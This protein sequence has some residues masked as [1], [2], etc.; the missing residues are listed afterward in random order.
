[1]GLYEIV[2]SGIDPS[3]L[4]S[5]EELIT[6][7]CPQRQGLLVIIQVVSNEIFG[8]IAKLKTPHHKWICWILEDIFLRCYSLQI[9]ILPLRITSSCTQCT[10][11]IQGEYWVSVYVFRL[12]YL[13]RFSYD[14]YNCPYVLSVLY[15]F[16]Y[17]WICI[18]CVRLSMLT[19]LLF[20]LLYFLD[21]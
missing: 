10:F 21:Y 7:Q 5:A 18:F 3:P 12:Y 9:L 2:V 11:L 8:E 6:F 19:F 14:H 1:M 15:V 13:C 20:Y 16:P 17:R 4:V